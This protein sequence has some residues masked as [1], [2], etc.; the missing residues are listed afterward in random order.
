MAE[1][2]TLKHEGDLTLAQVEAVAHGRALVALERIEQRVRASEAARSSMVARTTSTGALGPT[3]AQCETIRLR[4][5]CF[6]AS[7]L[8]Y[9]VKLL[10]KPVFKP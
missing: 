2:I 3:P 5:S 1:I 9:S 7:G 6:S 8:T 10:P 4:C